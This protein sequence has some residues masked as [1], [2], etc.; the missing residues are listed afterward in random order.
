MKKYISTELYDKILST[1]PDSKIKNIWEALFI[2]TNLF[3]ELAVEA[4]AFFK[5]H[6]NNEEASNVTAY[7]K[8]VFADS[9]QQIVS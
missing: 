5:F 8:Q 3:D 9:K 2:M 4:A 6:Y 7:L 1:Y